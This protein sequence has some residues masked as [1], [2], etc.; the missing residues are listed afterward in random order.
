M[1]RLTYVVDFIKSTLFCWKSFLLPVKYFSNYLL[2]PLRVCTSI[3]TINGYTKKED[4][5]LYNL[6]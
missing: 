2:H 5:H 3:S 4:T 6:L 1:V